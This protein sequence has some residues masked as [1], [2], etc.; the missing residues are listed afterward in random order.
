MPDQI[1]EEV[2]SERLY[3]LQAAIND[4][5]SIFNVGCLGRTFDVLFEKAGRHPGQIVGRSP[6]LQAVQVLA[7][8]TLIGEVVPVT[9]IEVSANSLFGDL[10]SPATH[11][12][13]KSRPANGTFSASV[14][15]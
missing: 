3:R 9:I 1:A 13:L 5:Q 11:T 6:Y 12:N 8:A 2:K 4:R 7:P 10:V 15:S 14:E